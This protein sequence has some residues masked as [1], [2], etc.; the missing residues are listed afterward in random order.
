MRFSLVR[1][2]G[3]Q[4]LAVRLGDSLVDLARLDSQLPADMLGVLAGGSQLIARISQ[5]LKQ[6]PDAEL[7]PVSQVEWCLPISRPSKFVCLGL[8]YHEHAREANMEIPSYPSLFSRFPTSLVAH[9]SAIIR[10]SISSALDYEAELAVIIGKQGRHITPDRALEFVAGYS[11]FNDASVRDY[12]NKTTQWGPGKNFD[13][14]GG[15]GPEIVTP[16]ELPAGASGLSIM[17]RLNGQ[18]VQQGNTGDMIFNVAQTISLLSEFMT[19]EVG[20][21][22]VMGTPSGVGVARTPQLFMKQGDVCEVEIEG[23]GILRNPIVNEEAVRLAA[24]S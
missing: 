23:I 17:T 2:R 12:Q 3:H 14:T 15:F 8:N 16:D 9:G 6:V 11:V 7:V 22:I 5:L 10:P 13:A 19:L 20:D 24:N 4:L 18:V 21:V 1:H